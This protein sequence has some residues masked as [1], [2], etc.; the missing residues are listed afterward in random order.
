MESNQSLTAVVCFLQIN[1][2]EINKMFVINHLLVKD[3]RKNISLLFH[4]V[5]VEL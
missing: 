5:I 2:N 3:N 1:Q 4:V